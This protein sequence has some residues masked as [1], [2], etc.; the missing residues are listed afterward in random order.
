MIT[1][2]ELRAQKQAASVSGGVRDWR[3]DQAEVEKALAVMLPSLDRPHNM[4]ELGKKLSWHTG[5]PEKICRR[6]LGWLAKAG[7]PHATQ[8][9]GYALV[10]GKSVPLWRW[11]ATA[12]R[13]YEPLAPASAAEP[14]VS[15]YQAMTEAE[16]EAIIVAD[17][18]SPE[19][20]LAADELTRREKLLPV[21]KTEDIVDTS[22]W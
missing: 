4:M 16:L 6:S 22:D 7:H 3:A 15:G 13:S 19:S 8:D 5:V 18:N 11:H 21:G 9:G 20:D 14:A 17:P 1:L 10:Y 12:Q 2:A